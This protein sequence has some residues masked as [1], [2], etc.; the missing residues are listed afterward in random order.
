VTQE[1]SDVRLAEDVAHCVRLA[2][3][4]QELV[5]AAFEARERVDALADEIGFVLRQSK[6]VVGIPDRGFEQRGERQL[7]E[8]L[9]RRLDTFRYPGTSICRPFS[10]AL[11]L[12]PARP[13]Y[14]SVAGILRGSVSPRT[15]L[16]VALRL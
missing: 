16:Y 5:P 14:T 12:L 2:V 9:V 7:P 4:L 3:G 6:A 13:P 8:P 1:V 10:T 11:T 15:V